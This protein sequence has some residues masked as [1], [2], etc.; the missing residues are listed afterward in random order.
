MSIIITLV[1]LLVAVAASAIAWRTVREERRRSEARVAALMEASA[2]GG[3][4]PDETTWVD[5]VQGLDPAPEP[6]MP[7]LSLATPMFGAEHE[8]GAAARRSS[9]AP[10]AAL[11]VAAILAGV[12]LASR[13]S[14][15]APAAADAAKPPALELVSLSHE[16]RGDELTIVG[17][18]RNPPGGAS[19][20]SAQAVVMLFDPQ[21]RFVASARA[22]LEFRRLSPGDESPFRVT[23]TVPVELARY[24]V[25]FRGEEGGLLP[26]V[27]RRSPSQLPQGRDAPAAATPVR[28]AGLRGKP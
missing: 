2:L 21:N 6:E 25:S 18:V 13:S 1:S 24:R 22:P 20:P 5:P 3:T 27:D 7:A 9:W 8:T 15:S 26:H 14:A 23:A 17:L 19:L 4:S 12:W 28:H 11:G 16:K 10:A